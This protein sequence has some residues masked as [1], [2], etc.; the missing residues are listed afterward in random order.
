[1]KLADASRACADAGTRGRLL[2]V[3]HGVARVFLWGLIPLCLVWLVIQYPLVW[4]IARD[5]HNTDRS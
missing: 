4:Y 3:R 2:R 1:M 5:L